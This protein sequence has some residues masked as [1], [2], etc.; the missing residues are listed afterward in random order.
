MKAYWVSCLAHSLIE[1]N[2]EQPS[3]DKPRSLRGDWSEGFQNL[4]VDA[5]LKE[6]RSEWEKE[7]KPAAT[8]V[9]SFIP[10]S[11]RIQLSIRTVSKAVL[12]SFHFRSSVAEKIFVASPD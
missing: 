6:I 5:E 2:G 10:V 12:R 8:R 4:D 7:H 3:N 1:S 9:V 11:R